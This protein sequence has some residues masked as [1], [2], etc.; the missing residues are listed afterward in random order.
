MINPKKVGI[1]I[2]LLTLLL[3]SGCGPKV[4]YIPTPHGFIKDCSYIKEQIYESRPATVFIH[5]TLYP[6]IDIL[7]HSLDSPLGLVPAKVQGNGFIHARIPYLLNQSDPEQFPLESFYL[8]GWSGKFNFRARKKAAYRLY[9]SLR[10]FSGP[11]TIIAHSHGG[12]V[13]LNL[14]EIVQEY[15]D[16]NFRIERLVLI[17]CPVQAVT[18]D[19]V[20][21]PIFKK[22][23]AL[24]SE[25]DWDQTK[26]PQMFYEV[27]REYQRKTGK[28]IPI[29][30]KRKFPPSPNLIQRR[31]LFG[32]RNVGHLEFIFKPFIQKLPA[33]L[34]LIEDSVCKGYLN[35]CNKEYII[36]AP[37]EPGKTAELLVKK[38]C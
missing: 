18:E 15:N 20:K 23:I 36:N 37:R 11:I 34:R 30:S 13:A 21:S 3:L 38:I 19:N 9:Q 14:P 26:D 4:C 22:V 17:S 10:T 16:H 27:T 6:F 2:I 33:V 25:R 31:I 28:D 32:R 1:S 8:F 24:Y 5:G 12:N 29:L 7:I 35:D